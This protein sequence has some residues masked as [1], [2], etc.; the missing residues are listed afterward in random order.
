MA[1]GNEKAPAMEMTKWFDTNYH[2]IVPEFE[3]GM[4]FH[5]ASRKPLE[6]YLGARALGFD[7]RPVLLG[8]VSFTMLGKIHNGSLSQAAIADALVEVYRDLLRE[9]ASA[10]ATWVQIDEPCLGLDLSPAMR[11]VFG[12]VYK[13]LAISGTGISILLATYFSG[14]G[15]NLETALHLPIAGLHLDLVR[16][17]GQ[18][19]VALKM[20]PADLRLSLGVIDGRNVWRADLDRALATIREALERVG[21]GRIEIA[22]SCSLM[23]IPIDLEEE[24]QLDPELR[25]WLAFA[26]QKLN[27]VALLARA[28]A[29][30]DSPEITEQFA[31]N[32]R[33]LSARSTSGRTC[34][35][36]VRSRVAAITPDMRKRS[37]AF[38]A[39]RKKQAPLPLLPTTTIG[40]FPQTPE[41]RRARAGWRTGKLSRVDYEAMLRTE[42]ERAI[43][44]QE[45]IGLDVLVHGE[46]ERN[47]MVEHFGE[48]FNGFSF[49]GN[50]WVQSYGSRCVKPPII[51]GDVSRPKPV[52]VEWIRY[53]QSL[54][55]GLSKACSRD[56]SRCSNGHLSAT[57]CPGGMSACKWPWACAMKWTISSRPASSPSR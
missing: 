39:R 33:I 12:R 38:A 32:R 41:I 54:T 17:P 50:G 20:A 57:I 36:A 19:L 55:T 35:P 8:P 40:S 52:T 16:A 13:R 10:G 24:N 26:R 43:R 15:D 29:G 37:S 30:D 42:M 34:D 3:A 31:E 18:L 9:L 7:T 48:Q 46:F 27:E 49:T 53:A 23:H 5:L 56:R 4:E 22:P 11:K 51:F 21:P 25:M 45:E 1:R 6:E 2:Y 14:L 44:F 28:T 47:D